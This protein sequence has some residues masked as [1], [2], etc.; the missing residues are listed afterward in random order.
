VI[1]KPKGNEPNCNTHI[2]KLA[3][4]RIGLL[5]ELT[6]GD[7][8]ND[9]TCK[10]ITGGDPM[11]Y[12][13][14]FKGDDTIQPTIN[15]W[16]AT[17]VMI[18]YNGGDGAVADRLIQVP[19]NNKFEIDDSF[20]DKVLSRRDYFFSYIMNKGNIRDKFNFSEE[21][22]IAKQETMDDNIDTL[23]EY[24][25]TKLISCKN[26]KNNKPI[27]IDFFRQQYSKWLKENGH[28]ADIR[29]KSTFS[30]AIR[31][32]GIE[33]KESNSIRKLLNVRFKY[34]D[35]DDNDNDNDNNDEDEKNTSPTEN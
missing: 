22:K 17:N 31:T 14:L 19:F 11:N 25:D 27:K 32:Y 16:C 15:N 23:K 28:P 20:Q 34:D 1:V 5:S 2:E 6:N 21:M 18:K 26:D 7:E 4:N 24:I 3:K 35:E 29:H 8:L 33:T 10:Q 13:G 12:R 30:K 9:V